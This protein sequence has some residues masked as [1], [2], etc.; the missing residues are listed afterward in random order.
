[1]I[2]VDTN[3]WMFAVG[4]PHPLRDDARRIVRDATA[5]GVP[6]V[7]SSEV[8]QELLH[9]YLRTDRTD[10]L[11]A[12]L[13]LVDGVATVWPLEPDD[14]HTARDLAHQHPSLTARDLVHLATCLRRDVD[15]LA[16]FDRAL[17]AAHA[18]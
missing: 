13:L 8:L 12:A 11:D 2:F 18:S 1:M 6:L 10:T 7:T 9:V 16:T 15:T 5:T 14:V 17:A 3:V 4:R